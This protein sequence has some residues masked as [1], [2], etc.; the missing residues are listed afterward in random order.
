MFPVIGQYSISDVAKI[1]F[2]LH[3]EF[4]EIVKLDN[5]IG[6]SDMLFVYNADEIEK[7]S[8]CQKLFDI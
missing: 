1:S 2:Q 8:F 7:V 5:L 4:G 6:R 3:K